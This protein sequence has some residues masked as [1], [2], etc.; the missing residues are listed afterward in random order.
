MGTE[1]K[2]QGWKIDGLTVPVT[3]MNIIDHNDSLL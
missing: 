1:W 2:K 3:I